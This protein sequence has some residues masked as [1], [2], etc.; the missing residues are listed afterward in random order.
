MTKCTMHT[1]EMNK[2]QKIK[3]TKCFKDIFTTHD[4][5]TGCLPKDFHN[6]DPPKLNI[7]SP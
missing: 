4:Q 3:S 5:G 1:L 7:H 6:C 2:V